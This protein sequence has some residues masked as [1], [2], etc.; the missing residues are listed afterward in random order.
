MKIQ[1]KLLTFAIMGCP[2]LDGPDNDISYPD[3]HLAD[4]AR[5]YSEGHQSPIE[6]VNAL[7]SER[8]I[9]ALHAAVEL[10]FVSLAQEMLSRGVDVNACDESGWTALMSA[11]CDLS[12]H[13]TSAVMALVQMLLNNGANVDAKDQDGATALMM[14]HYPEVLTVLI[15]HGANINETDDRGLTALM[16]TVRRN[17]TWSGYDYCFERA[18]LLIQNGA[19]VN[20]KTKDGKTVLM[21]AVDAAPT[22]E[23]IEPKVFELLLE[24]GIRIDT[25]D[26]DGCTALMYAASYNSPEAV[27]LLLKHGANV[28]VRDAHGR[29]ALFYAFLLQNKF[30]KD[31]AA[32]PDTLFEYIPAEHH[33]L[34]AELLIE[35]GAS[36]NA[37]DYLGQTA[38]HVDVKEGNISAVQF[39]LNH[40]ADPRIKDS[41]GR[42]A[43]DLAASDDM[44]KAF[45]RAQTS[46]EHD[47]AKPAK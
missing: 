17:E 1:L 15:K 46:S 22:P 45:N 8:G 6:A 42:T 13:E 2:V 11:C 25:Q 23:G 43:F 4:P 21:Y 30:V 24:K 44:K 39:L 26:Q 32:E 36:V 10:G 18:H 35:N 28:D 37:Q 41:Q 34:S 7:A 14:T 33:F 16:H 19:N 31:L 5:N 40:G 27:G 47:N 3:E 29:T 12:E 20:I 38:L 9:T